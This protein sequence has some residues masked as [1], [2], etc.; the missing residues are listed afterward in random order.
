MMTW[1][2]VKTPEEY[3]RQAKKVFRE[4]VGEKLWRFLEEKEKEK[5]R[6]NDTM[7]VIMSPERRKW[8]DN[9]L[10]EE[11]YWAG[12]MVVY[13]DHHATKETFEQ[14]CERLA[15]KMVESD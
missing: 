10:V 14:A 4:A 13:I 9:K 1:H 6:N 5:K 11:Y 7:E 3:K 8:I 2:T 15:N 12:K